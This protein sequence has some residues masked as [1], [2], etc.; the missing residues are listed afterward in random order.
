MKFI[1]SIFLLLASCLS[2]LAA[3]VCDGVT[4]DTVAI[5]TALTATGDLQLPSGVCRITSD[6]VITTTGSGYSAGARIRGAGMF[7]TTILADYN[8]NLATG[9]IVRFET[10][11]AGNYTLG[12]EISNLSIKQTAGKTG[13]NGVQLTAAWL[14]NITK[15]YIFG[16]SG[17]GIVTPLR[18]DINIISDYY[19]DFSV[20]ISQSWIANNKGWGLNFSAGQSP[21][22]YKVEYSTI[23]N[24]ATGGIKS[25]TG[26]SKIISNLIVGNGTYG[27][28]G[29][30]LFDTAEGPSFIPTIE[31]N[32]FD[33]NFNYH[34]KFLRS[35]SPR[36]I[37]NR[38]LS[39]TYTSNTSGTLQSGSAFMRPSVH[40]VLGD[41]VKEV[42]RPLLEMNYHRTVTGAGPTTAAVVG[43]QGSSSLLSA[44]LWYPDYYY[45]DGSIQ[46][47]TGFTKYS[48]MPSDSSIVEVGSPSLPPPPPP[49]PPSGTEIFRGRIITSRDIYWTP[50]NLNFDTYDV[51]CPCYTSYIF[52]VP[53]TGSYTF[54]GLSR[55]NGLSSSENLRWF[56]WDA[57]TSTVFQYGPVIPATGNNAQDFS[58]N[59]GSLTLTAGARYMFGLVIGAPPTK[60][61]NVSDATKNWVSVIKN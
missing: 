12:S 47:S 27:G 60:T 17:D 45:P 11:G 13:L 23:A 36:V 7:R 21:G 46:N 5:Q 24:N 52:T 29:G 26:Q 8:G 56:I 38:F 53:T 42:W 40:V 37:Q 14:I 2:S 61:L 51:P 33:T 15:V 22:L 55:V 44:R 20:I 9:A 18:N 34:L 39:Q 19:Q 6:I 35:R 4:D 59:S 31:L 32:E 30:V 49:L 10:T 41:G 57:S 25:T 3:P 28:N 1:I 43:Y 16:L 50:T 58:F 48:G 54:T